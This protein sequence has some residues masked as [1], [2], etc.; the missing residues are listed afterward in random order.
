MDKIKM[1]L[2]KIEKS[3][4]GVKAL[5]GIEF[6]VRE[7]TVHALCGENGAGKSTLMK[8]IM[9]LYKA[10]KG[11]IFLDEKEVEI[12]SPIQ[13][14]DLGISMIAQELSYVPE[15]SV[16][17]N[18]F[19][20]RLPV[21][22]FGMIDWKKI[23]QESKRFLEEENLPYKPWQKL[24]TLTVSDI[25][26]LEIIKAVTNNAKI[27]IM[28][29]PT[30]SITQ[31]EV[32]NLFKK[33]EELK[34]KGVSIIY[35][36]HKMDEVFRIADDISILRDGKVVASKKAS[37]FDLESVISLMVGRK[38]ENAYPKED[39][40][41]GEK[42]L[43][44]DKLNKDKLFEDVDFYVKKGEI[45]GFAGLVGAGRTEVM[46]AVYGLDQ[47]D[48]G[49]V[50]IKS[51]EVNIKNP[52]D[53][54]KEGLILLSESR[55]DDGIVPVRSVM[56]NASLAS[57]QKFIYSGFAHRKKERNAVYESFMKMNVK[58]PTLDTPISS[59]SGGN[60]QKVLLS[61][62]MLSEPD[63]LILDEPTRGIDIGAK[64][65]IY[66]LMTDMVKEGK[67]IIMVSSE[68]PELI[69]MCD[70]IYVMNKGHISGMLNRDEFSQEDIMRYATGL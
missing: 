65:E 20:G 3:F 59:L 64:F 48:S 47:K 40:E 19:L 37:E 51:K 32:E 17:E 60:Q 46:R 2:S 54:I 27:I 33:I 50:K 4:P 8:I 49:T 44:I 28:D 22:G 18:L 62:W 42:V 43:E 13:A 29:E 26:I 36:S 67:A 38:I 35:I 52:A 30:S 7:G 12:K 10:D 23:R 15:L 24:K 53:S 61:R 31:S 21:K 1:R 68:L 66:K 16:E 69:G 70:R 34:Q 11:S 39:I 56:E 63:I 57:L 9:G 55:K 25:Q 41:L 5:D 45:V 58:T 14:R 6:S